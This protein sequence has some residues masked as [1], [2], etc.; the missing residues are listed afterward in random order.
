MNGHKFETAADA[1]T[2]ILGGS[3][4]FTLTSL[5]T[6]KHFTFKVKE[7]KEEGLNGPNLR[8]V[9]VLAGPDNHSFDE[10]VYLGFIPSVGKLQI[11]SGKKGRPDA[12]SFKALAWVLA[13]LNND[14]LPEQV[15]IQHEGRCC[16]C[17]R[18][19]TH[20]ESL[21]RGIG[22]ECAKHFG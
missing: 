5:K 21:D 14:N 18:V 16:K 15:K 8:F 19:L 17:N 11:V 3:A 20:P 1:K 22:P 13:H 7:K 12:P 9:N 6:G 10:S 4:V 2:F